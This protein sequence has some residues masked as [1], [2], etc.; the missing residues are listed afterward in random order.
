MPDEFMQ[1]VE[2][3]KKEV[4]SYLSKAKKSSTKDLFL[5]LRSE[6]E[7]I[8]TIHDLE[9][10]IAVVERYKS[11]A[12][13]E[14][15]RVVFDV[16][17]KEL[18]RL[19]SSLPK[20]I[21]PKIEEPVKKP[22]VKKEEKKEEEKAKKKNIP[23]PSHRITIKRRTKKV[24]TFKD[25]LSELVDAV[26]S[27]HSKKQQIQKEKHTKARHAAHEEHKKDVAQLFKPNDAPI[28]VGSKTDTLRKKLK[29][30]PF[31]ERMK[32]YMIYIYELYLLKRDDMKEQATKD[33]F[34]VSGSANKGV[35]GSFFDTGYL[36]I[37]TKHLF[38]IQ[39][40][41]DIIEEDD[42]EVSLSTLQLERIRRKRSDKTPHEE[43]LDGI[44]AGKLHYQSQ[45]GTKHEFKVYEASLMGL[46]ANQFCR[47]IS[48]YLL[49]NFPEFF[50]KLYNAL[51][52]ANIRILSN[53]YVNIMIFSVFLGYVGFG[54][55]FF[56][57]LVV[58]YPFFVALIR[59]IV[60]ATVGGTTAFIVLYLYPF[61]KLK[62]RARSIT[63][64]LPFAITN[65]A[66]VA[67][68]GVPPAKM[69]RLI[70]ESKDY[71]EFTAEIE[72]VVQYIE[73]FGYDLMTSLRSV[74][75]VTPSKP[76]K[77]FFEGI[78]NT[79]ESGGDLTGFLGQ[80]ADETMDS[81]EMERKKYNDTIATYSDIYTGILIAAPLFFVSALSLVS[82]LGGKVGS[83][84]VN[85]IIVAGTY[86]I[87]PLMN[88]GFIIFLTVSQP[89]V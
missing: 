19:R 67:S 42:S 87:I 79:I 14:S 4:D 57:I 12:K 34:D 27:H 60:I 43:V 65:M 81:Y 74:A 2:E 70:V 77:E 38:R 71:G 73:L 29:E 45:E 46:Y 8:K 25:N 61:Q 76:L 85:V 35:F 89:D 64:N 6:L 1:K 21:M 68:S 47:R 22:I 59:A 66:A 28:K 51:R 40:N 55:L 72:K 69:F 62:D 11:D 9:I 86:V 7:K 56:I 5:T 83:L 13:K 50:K 88:I 24:K 75:A 84:D 23:K 33:I 10:R 39:K 32:N 78:V 36:K 80:K 3:K 18:L 20:S 54:L 41:E 82:M 37:L 17:L 52:L 48:F 53:T 15:T 44:D 58:K 63:T 26:Q 49:K 31:F 30:G 16:L